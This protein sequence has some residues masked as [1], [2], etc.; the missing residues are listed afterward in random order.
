MHER[1]KYSL[2]LAVK[3]AKV[4]SRTP[5]QYRQHALAQKDAR[6]R[7]FVEETN[8]KTTGQENYRD[9]ITAPGC[10]SVSSAS[11]LTASRA[12][13]SE[14]GVKVDRCQTTEFL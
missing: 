8:K 12:R 3:R 1:T 5:A 14:D 10:A 11:S 9:I 13:V 6:A 4:G 2:R 7:G